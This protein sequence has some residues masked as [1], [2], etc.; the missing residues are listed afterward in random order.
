[1]PDALV[2]AVAVERAGALVKDAGRLDS[3]FATAGFETK[4]FVTAG[5]GAARLAEA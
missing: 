4:G 5:F 3:D 1:V 2:E